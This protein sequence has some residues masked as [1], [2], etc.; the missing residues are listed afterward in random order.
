MDLVNTAYEKARQQFNGSNFIYYAKMLENGT[1]IESYNK[2]IDESFNADDSSL[3]N[4][5]SYSPFKILN[6]ILADHGMIP[7]DSDNRN[8]VILSKE[9]P[10]G[11]N[12]NWKGRP[13][14]FGK[15]IVEEVPSEN[16]YILR[17]CRPLS[18]SFKT[19]C[20]D[21]NNFFT[22]AS[23]RTGLPRWFFLS[24]IIFSSVFMFWLGIFIL[25][26]IRRMRKAEVCSNFSF[27]SS[28]FM[29]IFSSL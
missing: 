3:D 21:I 13:L 14:P 29:I 23:M 27:H 15:P 9:L 25:S 8:S 10:P 2:P 12:P 22:C 26:L 6:A 17:Q 28:L 1:I 20:Y 7:V 5:E 18:F 24:T 19:M 16:G 11:R 4:D